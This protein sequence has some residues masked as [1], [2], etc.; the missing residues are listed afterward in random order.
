MIKGRH[1]AQQERQLRLK[2]TGLKSDTPFFGRKLE[3][4]THTASNELSVL[5][6]MSYFAVSA[7]NSWMDSVPSYF[8][9]SST[10]F[11]I[12]TKH[13]LSANSLPSTPE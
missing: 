4:G 2:L 1:G 11:C 6:F 7:N 8:L 10:L 3:G 5:S 13:I 9:K 12:A